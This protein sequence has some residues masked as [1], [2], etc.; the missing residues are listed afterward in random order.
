[1]FLRHRVFRAIKTVKYQLSKIWIAYLSFYIYVFFTFGVGQINA[2]F[3]ITRNIN[4]LS[5]FYVAFSTHNKH[6]AVSPCTQSVRSKPIHPKIACRAVI[7]NQH[8]IPEILKLRILR[9]RIV[10]HLTPDDSC[11]LHACKIKELF[12]LMTSDITQYPAV[13]FFF[14]KPFRTAWRAKPVRA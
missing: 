7:S 13:F 2:P 6:P 5:K 1:M 8:G 12:H 3:I 11:I 4:V 9:V 10:C 14:K